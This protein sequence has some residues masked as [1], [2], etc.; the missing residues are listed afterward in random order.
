MTQLSQVAELCSRAETHHPTRLT[1]LEQSGFE[2]WKSSQPDSVQEWLNATGFEGKGFSFLP[3]DAAA[4]AGVLFVA[5]DLTDVFAT[6]NL[7]ERLPAGDYLLDERL[8]DHIVR[9]IA[10]AW[11]AATYRFTRYKQSDKALPR[12]GLES[13]DLLEQVRQQVAAIRLVR[14]LVNTPAADMMPEHL[15]D[16]A[17]GV[18]R[19]FGADYRELVGEELISHNYPMIH[20]VGRAS[21][22]NP[23]LLDIRWGQE[24]AP[25]ITL[26]GKGVCFD[27]GGLNIKPGNYMRQMKKDMGG[28]AHVLGLAAWIMASNLPVNLRVL[29]PAVENAVSGNAFRP[30]DVLNTR[31]GLT[32][33]IDNTDAE[34]RL[35]LCDALAEAVTDKPE[36]IIDF[37]TLTGACRVALG[38]ELP[39]FFS[40]DRTVARALEDAGEECGEPVWRLPLHAPYN[41][42]LKSDI[43]DLVNGAPSPYGGAI[44]AALYLERFVDDIP[45]VHFDIMAWNVRKL[46]GRPVGGEAM[47]VRAVYEYLQKRFGA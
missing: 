29:I 5:A 4:T 20:A 28:S 41:D 3:G 23:R 2:S 25:K 46:P 6:A 42:F 27:S 36:L 8:D 37:A 45:W 38:T 30:G 13:T 26:V 1:I 18:A 9:N 12:L 44:T 7:A 34:G 11:G 22:H 19:E 21:V 16:V 17:I 47:G 35:V 31:K 39:G 15:A 32:V 24:D 40:N 33:E 43:A 14:D 10:F